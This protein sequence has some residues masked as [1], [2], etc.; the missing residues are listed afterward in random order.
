MLV[1]LVLLMTGCTLRVVSELLAYQDYARWAWNVLPG[2]ALIELT[3]VALFAI[4]LI[5]TFARLPMV[6]WIA[7]PAF[8][9]ANMGSCVHAP[10]T[11]AATAS[12]SVELEMASSQEF[13][14][15]SSLRQPW[16]TDVLGWPARTDESC[17][18]PPGPLTVFGLFSQVRSLETESSLFNIKLRAPL[19]QT[20]FPAFDLRPSSWQ[21]LSVL[22]K[23]C[24][25]FPIHQG[26]QSRPRQPSRRLR[27]TAP[28]PGFGR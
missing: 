2:S 17:L 24:F 23:S 1:M 9:G 18:I 3:A 25:E 4:N 16:Q 27:A 7:C 19:R 8:Q 11:E 10:K 13:R 22:V 15:R 14:N 20:Q 12:S 28:L 26:I 6:F 5:M 21:Q